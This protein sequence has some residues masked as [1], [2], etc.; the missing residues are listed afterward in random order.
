MLD[1]HNQS[2]NC[3]QLLVLPIQSLLGYLGD[4]VFDAINASPNDYVQMIKMN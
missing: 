4:L 3:M 1:Y 2:N